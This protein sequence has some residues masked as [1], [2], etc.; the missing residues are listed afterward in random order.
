MNFYTALEQCITQGKKISR[1]KYPNYYLCI[2]NESK[3]LVD[4]YCSL[5]CIDID[6]IQATDWIFVEED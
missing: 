2:N 3:L 4:T 6:D 5:P 1:P